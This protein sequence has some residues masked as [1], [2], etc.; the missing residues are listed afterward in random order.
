VIRSRRA[1][2]GFL[3]LSIVDAFL[4]FLE[5]RPKRS[6]ELWQSVRAEQDQHDDEDHEQFLRSKSK[7]HGHSF[8]NAINVILLVLPVLMN[9]PER[10]GGNSS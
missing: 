3:A 4:E 10:A 1:D 9:D 7:H 6:S 8:A 2:A 5:A